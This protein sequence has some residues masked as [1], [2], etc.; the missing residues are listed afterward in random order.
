[1]RFLPKSCV[2]SVM[3]EQAKIVK[4]ELRLDWSEMDLF[5]H[6]NNVSYFKYLQSARVQFWE[7]TGLASVFRKE[8]KGPILA[9]VQCDFIHPLHYPGNI[10][11]QSRLIRIGNTSFQLAHKI[12]S[13]TGQ[14]CAT[15]NDALVMYDHVQQVKLQVPE[16]LKHWLVEES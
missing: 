4:L 13:S 3:D 11:I 10:L 16:E 7:V 12:H 2:I 1:M 14:L 15:G 8:R 6:I 9:S 5:G